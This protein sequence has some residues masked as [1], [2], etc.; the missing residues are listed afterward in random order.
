ME[1]RDWYFRFGERNITAIFYARGGFFLSQRRNFIGYDM[2][3]YGDYDW[4]R[5]FGVVL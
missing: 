2:H 1:W 4:R 5:V 3:I